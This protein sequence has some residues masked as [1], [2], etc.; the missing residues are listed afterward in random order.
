[1]F[2]YRIKDEVQPE[3]NSASSIG[4]LVFDDDLR[5]TPDEQQFNRQQIST[6]KIKDNF[7]KLRKVS[8][9]SPLPQVI[10]YD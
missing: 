8:E 1:M 7:S 6:K 4:R 2:F 9:I 5:T 10:L 3:R